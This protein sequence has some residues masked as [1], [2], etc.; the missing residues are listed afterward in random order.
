LTEARYWW[1]GTAND[2]QFDPHDEPVHIFR[3]E[4]V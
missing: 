4:G 1:Q 2:V 3:I